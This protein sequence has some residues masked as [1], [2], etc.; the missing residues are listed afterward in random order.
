MSAIV[1]FHP[2]SEVPGQAGLLAAVLEAS[3]EGLAVVKD[4]RV[5]Y[6]NPAFSR[7]FASPELDGVQG[8]LLTE[9][10]PE[11]YFEERKHPT[12]T[13]AIAE[14]VSFT[15]VR[16]DKTQVYLNITPIA[17]RNLSVVT[18]RRT[19]SAQT[20]AKSAS[21]DSLGRAVSSVVHDFNNLI[22]GVLLYSEL[23][24][25]ELPRST[26]EHA[27]ALQ[28]RRAAENGARLTRQLL[29][30]ARPETAEKDECC[31]NSVIAE[32]QDLFARLAGAHIHLETKLADGLDAV[33]LTSV[34]MQQI[35][36]NLVLN[37]R[38]AMPDGGHLLLET[39]CYPANPKSSIVLAVTDTGMG[40]SGDAHNSLFEPFFTTKAEGKGTGLGLFSIANI[41]KQ[42][43][44]CIQV[45][46]TAGGGTRVVIRMSPI[47]K[48]PI[49]K[50]SIHKCTKRG[51]SS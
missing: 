45:E 26:Q 49:H 41:V 40:M 6:S 37:A 48:T 35:L 46:S 25:N 18:A 29:T 3:P 9:I 4:G 7:L 2:I 30:I 33:K 24:S 21:L 14:K 51:H 36:L 23:L 28:I 19:I 22:T 42:S 47:P 27:H 11:I 44:G 39:S 13:G 10:I 12:S 50:S 20:D 16:R 15:S 31:W 17:E 5:V 1:Q 34:Q 38:D 43:G 32:M 8:R